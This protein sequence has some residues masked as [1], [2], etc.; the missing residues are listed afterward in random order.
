MNNSSNQHQR[1]SYAGTY[2]VTWSSSLAYAFP[3]LAFAI[4]F[5]LSGPQLI[6]GTIVNC[7]LILSGSTFT[8]KQLI[9]L[10]ILPSIGA[11]AH[12]MVFASFT[13]YLLY[14]L[15]AIWLGNLL[16]IMGWQ[17]LSNKG[18]LLAIGLSS[19]IKAGLL[20]VF[21]LAFVEFHLVPQIF[22][23][24]MS[25]VQLITALLGGFLALTIIRYQ[26][27]YE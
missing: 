12:G 9:P 24:A 18:L 11:V 19:L 5:L 25:G 13:P 17:F 3:I 21:A 14:F 16:Y 15:P 23:M 22:L 10:A 6:V 1:Q 7:F 26:K 2:A 27:K 4:P 20:S 8:R